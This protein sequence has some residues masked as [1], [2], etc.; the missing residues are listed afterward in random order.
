MEKT[1]ASNYRKGICPI[2]GKNP[3]RP[4]HWACKNCE[5]KTTAEEFNQFLIDHGSELEESWKI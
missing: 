1:I 3:T 5:E 2:C 4:D